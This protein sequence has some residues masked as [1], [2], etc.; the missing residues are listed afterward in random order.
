MEI[1]SAAL[2]ELFVLQPV[3]IQGC[4]TPANPA[5][6]ADG[7]IPKALYDGQPQGLEC[8]V[9]SLPELQ[10]RAWT[11]AANDLVDLFVN[12][13]PRAATG[14]TVAEGEEQRC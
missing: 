6:R 13:N 11:M 2:N 9:D 3:I 1:Q 5:D 4:V 14:K 8:L 7:G 12:D 10:H